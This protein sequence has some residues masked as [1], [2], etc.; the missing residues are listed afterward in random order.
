M[1]NSKSKFKFV[2]VKKTVPYRGGLGY[3]G[4][5]WSKVK[6][7]PDTFDTMKEAGEIAEIFNIFS[8]SSDY[9]VK[10]YKQQ[11]KMDV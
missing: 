8:K 9:E 7:K 11:Y 3:I 2:V 1:K 6:K 5:L 10:V 4:N